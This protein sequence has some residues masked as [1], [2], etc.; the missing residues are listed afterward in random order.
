MALDYCLLIPCELHTDIP[1][2]LR[3][4]SSLSDVSLQ[5]QAGIEVPGV[6]CAHANVLYCS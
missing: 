3:L 4:L 1:D 5:G 6:A 2:T